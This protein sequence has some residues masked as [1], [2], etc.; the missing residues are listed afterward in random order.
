MIEVKEMGT[1]WKDWCKL[2]KR[3]FKTVG[4][5]QASGMVFG[6]ITDITTREQSMALGERVPPSEG[7]VTITVKGTAFDPGFDYPSLPPKLVRDMA[8][9]DAECIS[10]KANKA[11][12]LRVGNTVA[13]VETLLVMEEITT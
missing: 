10:I 9:R 7:Y 12:D 6:T 8:Q 1:S 4:K 11:K 5:L 3:K 13:I 2:S